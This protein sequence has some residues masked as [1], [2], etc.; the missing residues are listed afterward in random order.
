MVGVVGI[1]YVEEVVVECCNVVS[2]CYVDELFV[3]VVIGQYVGDVCWAYFVCQVLWMQIDCYGQ[4]FEEVVDYWCEDW[5]EVQL[6][7][8]VYFWQVF[9]FQCQCIWVWVVEF[10]VI[11]C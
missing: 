7:L 2:R 1:L 11:G 9:V 6:V 10:W 4:V 8:Y 5:C 3:L